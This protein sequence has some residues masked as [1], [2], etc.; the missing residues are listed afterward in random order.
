MLKDEI[1]AMCAQTANLS[2]QAAT[3]SHLAG[4]LARNA[5]EALREVER[6][7]RQIAQLESALQDIYDHPESH[8]GCRDIAAAALGL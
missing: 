4:L 5:T 3:W 7:N 8:G 6:L 2:E 1:A